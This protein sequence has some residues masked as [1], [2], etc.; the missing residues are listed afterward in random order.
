MCKFPGKTQNPVLFARAQAFTEYF[1]TDDLVEGKDLIIVPCDEGNG[2]GLVGCNGILVTHLW[3][4]PAEE[5]RSYIG[6]HWPWHRVPQ[7]LVNASIYSF[8]NP[9]PWRK[10]DTLEVESVGI[11]FTG[12]VR[13]RSTAWLG[14]GHF[15]TVGTH[16]L[17]HQQA[18]LRLYLISYISIYKCCR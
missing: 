11:I 15:Q 4:R 7:R 2:S 1:R 13:A 5:V 3:M 17:V 12:N 18:L 10:A 6:F 8:D 14:G 9:Y 16:N